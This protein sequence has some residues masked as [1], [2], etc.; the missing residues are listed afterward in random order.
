MFDRRFAAALSV[1]F[2]LSGSA[3]LLFE[4]LWFRACGLVFGNSA[5]ASAI[6]LA[7]F[8]AGLAIGN[9]LSPA[10][11]RRWQE[12]LRVYG[13]LEITIG[14][15]GLILVL[16]LPLLS[17]VLAP[18]FRN[19]LD[20]PLLNAVRMLFAFILLVIPATGMGATL[21]TVV[22]A[23]SRSDP[24]FGRVLGMLYGCNTIGA[25][26]GALAGELLLIRLLGVRGTGVVA[27]LCSV[28]AG[29][30][31]LSLRTA[32][33]WH[34]LQGGGKP[35]HS[36]GL[37]R[38]LIAASAS[39]FALLALEVLW[40]RFVIFFVVSTSVAFAV[41]LA[42]VLAGIGFGALLASTVWTRFPNADLNAPVV[43]AAAAAALVLCYSGFVAFRAEAGGHARFE[44]LA[45]VVDSVRLML[46]VSILSGIFFTVIGRSVEREIGEDAAALVTFANT[47]GAAIGPVVAGF[48]FIPLFGVERSFFIVA[49]LYAV[50]AALTI[51]AGVPRTAL[52]IA[53]DEVDGLRRERP[54]LILER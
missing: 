30:A 9:L 3:S 4:T 16:L 5:W 45:V 39:G 32:V 54:R 25:V 10:V 34:R 13:A 11:L 1:I 40:F 46:P 8:M 48:V 15:C 49:M 21:P 47:I 17:A 22:T 20:S 35:P 52:A 19:L 33:P 18:L 43:A 36:K 37:W 29:L 6:V 23:L 51:R 2:F 53:H 28:S 12:P 50:I 42:V 14:V 24:N 38:L 26:A 7:S 27:A 44:T 31:A 41:M